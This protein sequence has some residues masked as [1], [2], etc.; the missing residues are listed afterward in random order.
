[1]FATVSALPELAA[2]PTLSVLA[3]GPMLAAGPVLAT[4]A[5]PR[6]GFITGVTET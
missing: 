1:V 5:V 2:R 3:E 4:V 6:L